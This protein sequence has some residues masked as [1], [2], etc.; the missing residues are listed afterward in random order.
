MWRVLKGLGLN[1]SV[2][3]RKP[4]NSDAN[5]KLRLQFA[6]GFLLSEVDSVGQAEVQQHYVHRN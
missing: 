5:L 6:I 3:L 1:N 2:A 4:P